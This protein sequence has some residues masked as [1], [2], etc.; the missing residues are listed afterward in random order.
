MGSRSIL[1]SVVDSSRMKFEKNMEPSWAFS[2]LVRRIEDCRRGWNSSSGPGG[3]PSLANGR[4]HQ[5]NDGT[6]DQKSDH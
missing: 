3:A 6:D 5:A 1:Y 4:D 2:L